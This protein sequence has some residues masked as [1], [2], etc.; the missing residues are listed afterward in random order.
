[1]ARKRAA[2]KRKKRASRGEQQVETASPRLGMLDD[3]L[4]NPPA[5]AYKPTPAPPDPRWEELRT[6]SLWVKAY[7]ER[8]LD[9]AHAEETTLPHLLDLL[10]RDQ[11]VETRQTILKRWRRA[12]ELAGVRPLKPGGTGSQRA[13]YCFGDVI[14]KL[15]DMNEITEADAARLRASFPAYYGTDQPAQ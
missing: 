4:I 6:T 8:R 10:K 14:G 2:A 15:N 12:L 5:E 13:V 7:M 9:R 3:I 11:M 1:M